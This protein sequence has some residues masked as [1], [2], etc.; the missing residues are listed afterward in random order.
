LR[1]KKQNQAKAKTKDSALPQR[2]VVKTLRTWRAG[3]SRIR[4]VE[5]SCKHRRLAAVGVE[6]VGCPV[7]GGVQRAKPGPRGE[8]RAPLRTP[9]CTECVRAKRRTP[10]HALPGRK[11]CQ[12]CT[13]KSQAARRRKVAAAT[14]STD[15]VERTPLQVAPSL[16]TEP[17][18][19]E[20]EM[21][22]GS[23]AA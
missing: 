22:A 13:D 12:E 16:P 18:P 7:C 6:K 4:S 14:L 20:Q 19:A 2:T 21:T 23:P 15:A 10:N 1:P 11:L 3:A 9:V 17:S 5:L 8:D